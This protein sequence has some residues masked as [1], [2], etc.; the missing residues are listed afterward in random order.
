MHTVCPGGPHTGGAFTLSK[1]VDRLG[2]E[3]LV[4]GWADLGEERS[5]WFAKAAA[6]RALAAVARASVSSRPDDPT[7]VSGLYQTLGGLLDA[8][9]AART[10]RRG[11]AAVLQQAAGNKKNLLDDIRCLREGVA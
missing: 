3:A 10:G 2:L 9:D 6:L 11:L 5:G 7:Y 1:A 4:P 8:T